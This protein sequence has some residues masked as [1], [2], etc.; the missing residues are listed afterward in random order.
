MEIGS[1][2]KIFREQK[3]RWF[4]LHGKHTGDMRKIKIN[5]APGTNTKLGYRIS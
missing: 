2:E 1:V 4:Q 5:N 3:K